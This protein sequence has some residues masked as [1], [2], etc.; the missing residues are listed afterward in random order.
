MRRPVPRN[1]GAPAGAR[2]ASD[3]P[4]VRENSRKTSSPSSKSTGLT[5]DKALP[6]R[7]LSQTRSCFAYAAGREFLPAKKR[8]SRVLAGEF[9]PVAVLGL[10]CR[11]S[12]RQPAAFHE[13]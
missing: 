9:A 3:F 6:I 5:A 4:A 1:G 10:H 12:R 7:Y 11:P 13:E 2:K 8:A